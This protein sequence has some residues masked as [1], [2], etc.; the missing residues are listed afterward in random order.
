L[1]SRPVK[2]KRVIKAL[3]SLGFEAVRQ[4]GSHVVMKHPDGRLTVVPVHG[5]EELGRGILRDIIKDAKI[6]K[7]AFFALLEQV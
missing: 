7:D 3:E 1:N 4:K 5:D 2:P 6:A